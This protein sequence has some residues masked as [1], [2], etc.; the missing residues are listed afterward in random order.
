MV[1]IPG[2]QWQIAVCQLFCESIDQALKDAGQPG[3]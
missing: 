3:I 2:N 1:T